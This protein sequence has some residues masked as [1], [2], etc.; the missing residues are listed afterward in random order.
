V[1]PV[2]LSLGL[3]RPGYSSG[4]KSGGEMAGLFLVVGGVSCYVPEISNKGKRGISNVLEMQV[5]IMVVKKVKVEWI[6]LKA[7]PKI[8]SIHLLLGFIQ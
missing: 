4:S 6:V 1:S 5:A 2:D 7:Q 8:R 3:H